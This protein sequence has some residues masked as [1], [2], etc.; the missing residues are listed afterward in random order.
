MR[1]PGPQK[2]HRMEENIHMGGD[3]GSGNIGNIR[4]Y[5]L[6]NPKRVGM[7]ERIR[8]TKEE[9]LTLVC[10]AVKGAEKPERMTEAMHS[11]AMHLLSEKGLVKYKES[12]SGEVWSATLTTK[13]K[14]YMEYNPRLKNPVPWKDILLITLSAVTAISTMLALFIACTSA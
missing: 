14:A 6:F 3:S 4:L 13:G 1:E 2:S 11:Y 12:S 9:K 5:K 10:V 7:M 8:L